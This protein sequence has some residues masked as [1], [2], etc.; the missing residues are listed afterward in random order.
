MPRRPRAHVG[1]ELSGRITT[2]EIVRAQLFDVDV[3]RKKRIDDAIDYFGGRTSTSL[4]RVS[5]N[6]PGPPETP[7]YPRPNHFSHNHSR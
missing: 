2:I 4:G 6:S 1:V 7:P 3:D 5:A